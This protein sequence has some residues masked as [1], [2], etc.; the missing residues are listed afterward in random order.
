MIG[1][2]ITGKFTG[3]LTEANYKQFTDGYIKTIKDGLGL[4]I[5][6]NNVVFETSGTE[7]LDHLLNPKE[8]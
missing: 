7:S 6:S 2:E 4:D 5:H 3:K 1:S 8:D